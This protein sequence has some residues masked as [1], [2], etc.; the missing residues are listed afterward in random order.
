[1]EGREESDQQAQSVSDPR[2]SVRGRYRD[3]L[4]EFVAEGVGECAPGIIDRSGLPSKPGELAT[5]VN[6]VGC[7]R[8]RDGQEGH[9]F[10]WMADLLGEAGHLLGVAPV[11]RADEVSHNAL[12]PIDLGPPGSQFGGMGGLVFPD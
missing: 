6:A 4:S 11:D 9:G 8:G 5:E 7:D 1:M 2:R 10:E 3:R 12:Q